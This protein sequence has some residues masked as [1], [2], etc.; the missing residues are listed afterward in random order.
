M[1]NDRKDGLDQ[2]AAVD[3]ARLS[4]GADSSSGRV[5]TTGTG[6]K[7]IPAFDVLSLRVAEGARTLSLLG[8]NQVLHH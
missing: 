2:N 6:Q 8:H 7:P 4:A 1:R 3:G 5:N